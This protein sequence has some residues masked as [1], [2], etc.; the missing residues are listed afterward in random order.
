MWIAGNVT[1]EDIYR[2]M[3]FVCKI[4]VAKLAAALYLKNY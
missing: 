4:A 3:D 1:N 2:S